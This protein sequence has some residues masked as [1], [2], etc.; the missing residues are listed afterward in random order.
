MGSV[1]MS[2]RARCSIVFAPSH[3]VSEAFCCAEVCGSAVCTS[4]QGGRRFLAF[5]LS[6]ALG[7]MYVL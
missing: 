3:H 2:H 4:S 6:G 7:P 1:S 5:P